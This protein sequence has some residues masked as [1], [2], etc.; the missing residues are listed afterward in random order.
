MVCYK[1]HPNSVST[2]Y[3]CAHKCKGW[4]AHRRPNSEQK[5]PTYMLHVHL[6]ICSKT[7]NLEPGRTTSSR[8]SPALQQ[9]AGCGIAPARPP[10][11]LQPRLLARLHVKTVRFQEKAGVQVCSSFKTK[12]TLL[13]L[14]QRASNNKSIAKLSLWCKSI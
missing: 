4:S 8:G 11:S 6:P 1:S 9:L 12:H 14:H 5:N 13:I 7:M 3:W 10:A 2:P